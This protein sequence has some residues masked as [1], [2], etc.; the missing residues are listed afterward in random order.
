ML[1]ALAIKAL[2]LTKGQEAVFSHGYWE[3]KIVFETLKFESQTYAEYAIGISSADREDFRAI[4]GVTVETQLAFED[5]VSK[6]ASVCELDHW[7]IDLICSTKPYL[8][9]MSDTHSFNGVLN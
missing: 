8:A 6:L 4:Y 3:D 7:S 5:Y 9:W 1:S 2:A